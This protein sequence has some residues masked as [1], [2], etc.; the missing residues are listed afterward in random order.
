MLGD[1][2]RLSGHGGHAIH[3]YTL[4]RRRFPA[5]EAASQAAFHLGRLASR[6]GD[7]APNAARWFDA[8]LQEQPGG[9]LAEA[10]L[11]RMLEVEV[12]R[13]NTARARQLAKT[14]LERHP[15]GAHAD[16]AREILAARA[17]D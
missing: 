13:K 15:L 1:T 10:A 12:R 9:P 3:A 7:D 14:Y 8:Y 16:A 11:G 17:G 4:L 2:A 5:S 6:A